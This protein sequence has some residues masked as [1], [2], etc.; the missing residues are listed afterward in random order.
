MF[1]DGCLFA[2]SA[3]S[4][5]SSPPDIQVAELFQGTMFIENDYFEALHTRI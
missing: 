4:V 5:H 2:N 3:F 1:I